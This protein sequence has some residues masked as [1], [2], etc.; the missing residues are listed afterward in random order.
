MIAD[1]LRSHDKMPAELDVLTFQDIQTDS[2]RSNDNDDSLLNPS[3]L[4]SHSARSRQTPQR[5]NAI[6]DAAGGVHFEINVSPRVAIRDQS[7]ANFGI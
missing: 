5:A 7:C 2:Y 6:R 4:K 1:K 3:S